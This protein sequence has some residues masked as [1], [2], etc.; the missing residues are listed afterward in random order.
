MSGAGR[1]VAVTGARGFVGH[2]LC[3][4]LAMRGYAVRALVR[5]LPDQVRPDRTW[6]VTGDLERAAAETL[7]A[8]LR[9]VHAVVHLAGRAHVLD[10][11]ARD[12]E[13]AYHAA[14][15]VATERLAEA[16]VSAGV[17]RL[18][19]AS[20]VKVNGEATAMGHPFHPD[21]TPDPGDAY[22][23]SKLHAENALRAAC[24]GAATVPL[25]VRLPL[26]YGPG[27]RG[28]M[29]T[30]VDAVA[31]ERRLPVGA[32]RNRRSLAY[33]LNVTDAIGA[34]VDAAIAPTGVHFIADAGSV[35][36]PELVRAIA[37]ALDLP[38][39]VVRVPV[40]LLRLAGAL[41]GRSGMIG[42]LADSLEVD[43]SSFT[44]MTG[45]QPRHTL[46]DG[47]AAL[48]AWWRVRHAI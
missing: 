31:A 46:A 1:I 47:L 2:A 10:E 20:S 19:L 15:A 25:V 30:L 33:V 40:P 35:S 36:T 5:A 32:I 7:A 4:A 14:N 43:P 21:D 13:A 22:A 6:V 3:G 39:H 41:T 44:N 16:T 45:W 37:A 42:R 29:L 26:V 34:A 12:P 28:N 8:A 38:A 23:R 27:V 17:A 24:A 18:I 48:V 9:D 11:T